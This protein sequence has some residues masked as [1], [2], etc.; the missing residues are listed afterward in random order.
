MNTV[1][2]DATNQENHTEVVHAAEGPQEVA[3]VELGAV[4][5]TRGGV[6]GQKPDPGNGVWQY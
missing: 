6:I 4:S 3:L 5:E 1:P 2:R